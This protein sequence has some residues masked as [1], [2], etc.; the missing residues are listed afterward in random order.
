MKRLL[1][2]SVAAGGTT[3]RDVMDV[4]T[5]SERNNPRRDLTGFLIYDRDRF[6]QLLEGPALEVEALMAVIEND[7]RHE[8]IEVL[9]EETAG[10]RWFPDWSMKRLITFGSVPAQEE[11][12]SILAG[13]E[14]GRRVL[15]EVNRFLDA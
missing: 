6:L 14:E 8:G 5:S 3:T 7:P 4:I 2:S 9:L 11:L 13:D 10:K 12:S 1:Y 15:S